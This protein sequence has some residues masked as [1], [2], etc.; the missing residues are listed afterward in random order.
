[1]ETSL[2]IRLPLAAEVLPIQTLVIDRGESRGGIV[3][4][5]HRGEVDRCRR[6]SRGCTA[7]VGPDDEAMCYVEVEGPIDVASAATLR[8]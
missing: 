1:M 5:W 8:L 7:I 6:C 4:R 3:R 2:T